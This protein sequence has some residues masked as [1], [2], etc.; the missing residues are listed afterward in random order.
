M[1]LASFHYLPRR[2]V[3][4]INR[5]SSVVAIAWRSLTTIGNSYL[6]LAKGDRAKLELYNI[7]EDKAETNNLFSAKPSFAKKLSQHL[8]SAR[9]SIEASVAGKDYPSGKLNPQPPRIFWTEVE[10]YRPHFKDWKKRPEYMSRLKSFD[11][12]I[13]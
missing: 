1:V 8:D 11:F 12:K 7:V 5:L 10:A 2:L 6:C 9:K 3:H 4:E 13:L